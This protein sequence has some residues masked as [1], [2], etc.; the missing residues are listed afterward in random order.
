MVDLSNDEV[1]K[2]ILNLLIDKI[3]RRSSENYAVEIIYRVLDKLISTYPFLKSIKI[4]DTSYSERNDTI[5]VDSDINNVPLDLFSK[6]LAAI[7][8]TTV[9]LLGRTA[10]FFFIREFDEAVSQIKG[11]DLMDYDIDLSTFQFQYIVERQQESRT[12]NTEVLE[13]TM[14]ALTTS[15]HRILPKEEVIPFIMDILKKLES[16]YTFL[17]HLQP[18]DTYDIDRVHIFQ[19]PQVIDNENV[20]DVAQVIKNILLETGKILGWERSEEFLDLFRRELLDEEYGRLKRIGINLD[21]IKII[22]L[23]QGHKPL[24]EKTINVLIDIIEETSSSRDVVSSVLEKLRSTHE[25]LQY[26]DISPN[27]IYIDNMINDFESYKLGKALR[28]L[29]KTV[30]LELGESPFPYIEEFKQ[31]LGEKHLR[32]LEKL[33]VNLHFLELKFT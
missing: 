25:V 8:K 24:V 10:D 12:K 1:A 29:I 28:D 19:I 23:R 20:S 15:L 14:R 17:K 11:L 33:G 7:I 32:D 6:A 5:H 13:S 21:H 3:S 26:I 31:R 22:L 16:R 4:V 2:I 27:G 30:G 18:L 9:E